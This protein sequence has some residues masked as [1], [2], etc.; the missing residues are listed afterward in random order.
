MLRG[1]VTTKHLRERDTERPDAS[2]E[3]GIVVVVSATQEDAPRQGHLRLCANCSP[4]S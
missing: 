1:M 3:S 2:P 4:R